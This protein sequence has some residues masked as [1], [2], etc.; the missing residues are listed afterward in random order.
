MQL[1]CVLL[2][3][4]ATSLSLLTLVEVCVCVCVCLGF[5]VYRIMLPVDGDNVISS[6]PVFP[7]SAGC[8][9]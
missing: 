2:R 7:K 1:I 6:F 4:P 3:C 8:Q 5:S 9:S